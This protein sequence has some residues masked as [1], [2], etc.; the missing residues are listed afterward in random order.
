MF[1]Y[2]LMKYSNLICQKCQNKYQNHFYYLF[3]KNI[4]LKI[5][6][7][8]D[9]DIKLY[10]NIIHLIPYQ[11]INVDLSLLNEKDY[12]N[13]ISKTEIY[14]FGFNKIIK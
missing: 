3:K 1:L 10:E 9:N 7:L 14:M 11:S 13:V 12:Y 8:N 4:K 2:K 6:I 5:S